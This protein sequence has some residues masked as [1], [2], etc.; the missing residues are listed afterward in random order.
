MSKY[1]GLSLA[2]L[3]QI[4]RDLEATQREIRNERLE[5]GAAMDRVI[6]AQSAEALI[7]ALSDDQKRALMQVAQAQLAAVDVKAEGANG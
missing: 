7:G 2:E 5:V 6:H 3:E 4:N 1:D